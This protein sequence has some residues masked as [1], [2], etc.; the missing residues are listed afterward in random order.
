MSIVR[1]E[2]RNNGFV[3]IP[4][5][6][7]QSGKLP[8]VQLG[9][10]AYVSS[11]P[12]SW[13]IYPTYLM[14]TFDLSLEGA[15]KLLKGLTALGY[16]EQSPD[17]NDRGQFAKRYYSSRNSINTADANGDQNHFTMVSNHVFQN[18]SISFEAKGL[19]AYL[20]TFP[21]SWNLIP[22]QVAT[23]FSVT[24]PSVK[25]LLTLLKSAGHIEFINPRA[26]NGRTQ[27]RQ[28]VIH[29]CPIDLSIDILPMTTS[30][31]RHLP[32]VEKPETYLQVTC[33]PET[34]LPVTQ[35]TLPLIKINTKKEDFEEKRLNKKAAA[36]V[37]NKD[38]TNST[39]EAEK[40]A[41]AFLSSSVSFNNTD[42]IIGDKLTENQIEK[43]RAVV[44][45]L[46]ATDQEPSI[47]VEQIIVPLLNPK[48]F[49]N[50]GLD[51]LKKLN[52]CKSMILKGLWTTPSL[53]KEVKEAK[54][55]ESKANDQFINE[56][57]NAISQVIGEIRFC[58]DALKMHQARGDAK[59]ADYALADIDRLNKKLSLI[60][61]ELSQFK[62][63]LDQGDETYAH[64]NPQLSQDYLSRY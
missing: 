40:P 50:A 27:N 1:A 61:Q 53:P 17:A 58:E 13:K 34:C 41:A 59:L 62:N 43:V 29:E 18:T 52:T 44:A 16:L 35:N 57:Q 11:L 3:K 38:L 32:V 36:K 5:A 23:Q 25:K 60:K 21:N 26:A 9:F 4:N 31:L 15:N 24:L 28:Y 10:L 55:K 20:L 56:K 42:K 7:Y 30:P 39:R 8:F 64:F 46:G 45:S 33:L 12:P 47:L 19:L 6:L 14:A 2:Y 48:S 37:L 51:F 54:V 49:S 22:E 63:M